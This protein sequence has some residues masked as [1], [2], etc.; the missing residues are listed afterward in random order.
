MKHCEVNCEV[1]GVC[2]I[3]VGAEWHFYPVIRHRHA[4]PSS[5]QSAMKRGH[6]GGR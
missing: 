6:N 3:E 2:D 5:L 4:L 1:E